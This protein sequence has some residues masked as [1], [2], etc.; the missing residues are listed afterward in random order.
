MK[1]FVTGGTGHIGSTLIQVLLERG[2]EVY[3]LVRETSDL[4][5]LKGL[6]SNKLFFENGDLTSPESIFK[7]IKN[8]QPDYVFHSA[9]ALGRW[10]PWKYFHDLNVLGT[11][12]VVDAI[13]KVSSVKKLVHVSTFAVYGYR[14]HLDYKEDQPY[15]TLHHAYSETKMMAEQ[16][17]WEKYDKGKGLPISIIRPPSVFGPEDRRNLTEL[18]SLIK[19]NRAIVP[20]KGEQIN[21]WAYTYDI[22][23]L[24]L[25]MAENNNA[26]GEAFNVK[27][28]DI[29][30]ELLIKT[31]VRLLNAEDLKIRHVPIWL[32][33]VGGWLGSFF[34]TLLRK[35]KAPL[36][37]RQ[38][39]RMVIHHHS[40]NIDKA[41]EL[42][43]WAP[44]HT[45][46]DALRTTID[47]FI[48]S[49]IYDA[50]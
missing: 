4:K 46:E 5:F 15:G 24:L 25:K 29:S 44:Q 2:Y 19:Q 41:K 9:A 36:F 6:N 47:W 1:A 14:N 12:Y 30:S 23:D 34:G 31:L 20:G 21:S 18:L 45:L 32:T 50:L 11:K 40:C 10:G 39:V 43:D 13:E 37:H 7:G 22:A 33:R 48:N 42:L 16:F 26:T 27:T 49:G 8:A 28:G 35:E 3:C 38:I 17:L